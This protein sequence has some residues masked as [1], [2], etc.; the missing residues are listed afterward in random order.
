MAY[1]QLPAPGSINS[2]HRGLDDD[3]LTASTNDYPLSRA[4]TPAGDGNFNGNVAHH[5]RSGE[6]SGQSH[7]GS[8]FAAQR[9]PL[10]GLMPR[11]SGDVRLDER[12]G[13]N[14]PQF[15]TQRL[16]IEELTRSRSVTPGGDWGEDEMSP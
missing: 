2:I 13:Q 1:R 10:D 15:T 14:Y 7:P 4:G 8:Q 9:R 16:Q 5:D 11:V 6:G 12:E 3:I